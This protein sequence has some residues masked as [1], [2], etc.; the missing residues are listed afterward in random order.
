MPN[1]NYK[2]GRRKEYSVCDKLK[3]EGWEIVQRTAG[4]HS[5][6]DIF[7]INTETKEIRFIQVKAGEISQK[8]YDKIIEDNKKLNS[9]YSVEFELVGNN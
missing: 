9:K 7:A 4:S 2:K 5:P 6:I 8:E 3:I 1:P